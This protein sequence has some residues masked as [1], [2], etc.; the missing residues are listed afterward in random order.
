[1]LSPESDSGRQ[2]LKSVCFEYS[3]LHVFCFSQ[4]LTC[5]DGDRVE[6]IFLLRGQILLGFWAKIFL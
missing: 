3:S 4:L 1:M 6:L 2:R 5:V